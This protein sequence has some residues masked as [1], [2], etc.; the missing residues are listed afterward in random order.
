MVKQG[1]S[2]LDLVLQ[3]TGSIENA[4]EM[5]LLN[6]CSLTDPLE[7]GNEIVPTAVSKKSVTA[8]FANKVPATAPKMAISEIVPD[9]SGIGSMIIEESFIVN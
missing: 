4:F 1:Q 9:T 5:S 3:K 8:L 6:N 2:F 7:I